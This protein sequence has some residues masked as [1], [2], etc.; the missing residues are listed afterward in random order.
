[1]ATFVN[2]AGR[3]NPWSCCGRPGCATSTRTAAR[4]PPLGLV[5][6]LPRSRPHARFVHGN[7]APP[8]AGDR[9]LQGLSSD[10]TATLRQAYLK[11]VASKD[12]LDEA[13]KRGRDIGGRIPREMSLRGDRAYRISAGHGRRLPPLRG[14]SIARSP[15]PRTIW[16]SPKLELYQGGLSQAAFKVRTTLREFL[17]LPR[18]S[19]CRPSSSRSI[20]TATFALIHDGAVI[21]ETLV[22]NEYL[23]DAFPIRRRARR[24]R[25]S[26]PAC[27]AGARSSTSICST[28]S[29]PSAG[30]SASGR[31]CASG[32]RRIRAG[33]RAHHAP[34]QAAEVA[35]G[36]SRLSASRHRRGAGQDR[37][38]VARMESALAQHPYLAGPRG[39]RGRRLTPML[40]GICRRTWP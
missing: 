30:R 15:Q 6:G 33:A 39:D 24:A 27:G 4:R 17:R 23:Y 31:S 26:G 32:G 21:T 28:P 36:L 34:F 5:F 22:I 40:T 13:I 29:P 2:S 37:L 14:A 12:Y 10:V 8:P 38:R 9:A 1:M 20:P 18:A 35:Q 7:A 19:T 11:M 3:S 25:S 16:K